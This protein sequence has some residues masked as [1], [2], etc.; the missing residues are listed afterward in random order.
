M[1]GIRM[2]SQKDPWWYTPSD[3]SVSRKKGLSIFLVSFLL[4]LIVFFTIVS[5]SGSEVIDAYATLGLMGYCAF[6]ALIVAVIA[7]KRGSYEAARRKNQGET[8]QDSP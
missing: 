1:K 8:L 3:Q 7:T 5:S 2:S 4:P 6:L